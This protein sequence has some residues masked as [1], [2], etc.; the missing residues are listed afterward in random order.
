MVIAPVLAGMF[1]SICEYAGHLQV[2]Q[3]PKTN[4]TVIVRQTITIV[5]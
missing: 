4:V 3:D 5:L 1:D 2:L